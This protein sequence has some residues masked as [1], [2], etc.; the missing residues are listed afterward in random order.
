M[1]VLYPLVEAIRRALSSLVL[2]V[3]IL[4]TERSASG[5]IDTSTASPPVVVVT[6]SSGR[7]IDTR[8]VY[9]ATNS[10]SGEI[11]ARFKNSG[12]LLG[13]LYCSKFR[14]DTPRL[15]KGNGGPR[16]ADNHNLEQRGQRHKD[17]LRD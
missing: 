16:R 6:P 9:L 8:S 2:N 15:D 11:E 10:T 14:H 4:A 17:I 5:E 13:K 1:S 7:R 12:K 3:D